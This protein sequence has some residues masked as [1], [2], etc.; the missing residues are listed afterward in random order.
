MF[1]GIKWGKIIFNKS[2]ATFG[3]L[4]GACYDRGVGNFGHTN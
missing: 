2:L 3:L 4:R 1:L